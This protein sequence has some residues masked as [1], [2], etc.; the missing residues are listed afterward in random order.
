ME[1][2][3]LLVAAMFAA[4][5]LSGPLAWLATANGYIYI[6]GTIG[7]AAV[8]LGVWWA[9]AAPLPVSAVGWF[10]AALGAWC[11]AKAW[12]GRQP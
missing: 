9:S 3:A 4:V 11:I 7:V 12:R 2:L 5:A 8:G 6:G 10:S 1:S